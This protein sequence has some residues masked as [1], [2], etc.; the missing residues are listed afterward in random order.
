MLGSADNTDTNLQP[1]L[2][3]STQQVPEPAAMGILGSAMLL[4]NLR[5]R[6]GKV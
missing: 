4:L 6:G 3:L 2:T 5:R 1:T